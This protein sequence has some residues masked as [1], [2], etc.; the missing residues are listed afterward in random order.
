MNPSDPFSVQRR[1]P[2]D[3]AE[4]LR[5]DAFH[6]THSL[7]R[8]DLA[9]LPAAIIK[10]RIESLQADER[11]GYV[12]VGEHQ[13]LADY[14]NEPA[15]NPSHYHE[16]VLR[17]FQTIVLEWNGQFSWGVEDIGPGILDP[18]WYGETKPLHTFGIDANGSYF[19]GDGIW[20]N[21]AGKAD[22]PDTEALITAYDALHN[23]SYYLELLRP[24]FQGADDTKHWYFSGFS[25]PYAQQDAVW[26]VE[27]FSFYG[28]ER[29]CAVIN[30]T[31]V[32][33]WLEGVY[34][35]PEKVKEVLATLRSV[36]EIAQ[37]EA[38]LSVIRMIDTQKV[39]GPELVDA[40]FSI[41]TEH[42]HLLEQGWHEKRVIPLLVKCKSLLA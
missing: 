31:H 4:F 18:C 29:H 30:K 1:K 8:R 41:A 9:S 19:D 20:M 28:T 38:F 13:W 42:R 5:L 23:L 12:H 35:I 15:G 21:L 24:Y 26:Y 34:G 6:T 37:S 32:D 2:L 16:W 25:A 17:L 7:C 33:G 36:P 3:Q 40:L 27:A 22:R 10:A 11:R 14:L 39:R